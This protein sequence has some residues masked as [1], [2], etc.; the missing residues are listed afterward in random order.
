MLSFVSLN[1]GASGNPLEGFYA[2]NYSV[3][4][5]KVDASEFSPYLGDAVITDEG[6]HNMYHIFWDSS[7]G[8]FNTNVIIIPTSLAHSR[9]NRKMGFF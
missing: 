8:A 3:D 5:I 2:A 1:L 4:V 9:I 6:N 7:I